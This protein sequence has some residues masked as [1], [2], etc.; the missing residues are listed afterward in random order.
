M[1]KRPLE[2]FH[3]GAAA[4]AVLAATAIAPAVAA[5]PEPFKQ[6]NIHFETNASGCDMGIQMSFDTDGITEGEIEGPHEQRV[7]SFGSVFGLEGTHDLTE[8]FQERV[9]PPIIELENTL[10]CEPSEDAISLTELL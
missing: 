10:G 9:E 1:K 3:R 4:V 7:F 8:S 5:P 2:A 6:T